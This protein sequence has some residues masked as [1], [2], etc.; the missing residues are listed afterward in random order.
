[1][2]FCPTGHNVVKALYASPII[3]QAFINKK[4]PGILRCSAPALPVKLAAILISSVFPA[5]QV[6]RTQS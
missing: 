2:P 4:E 3:A 5:I 6:L 1:M